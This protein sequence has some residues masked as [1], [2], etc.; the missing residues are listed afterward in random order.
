MGNKNNKPNTQH[1]SHE[2][3]VSIQFE[4]HLSNESNC[5]CVNDVC[6]CIKIHFGTPDDRF[7]AS[8]H[9]EQSEQLNNPESTIYDTAKMITNNDSP[10]LCGESSIGP[11]FPKNMYGGS[12]KQINDNKYDDVLTK[13]GLDDANYSRTTS[14]SADKYPKRISSDIIN[15]KIDNVT[16]DTDSGSDV[17]KS[18]SPN[19]YFIHS[20]SSVNVLPKYI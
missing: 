12:K 1:E 19:P 8:K 14:S 16:Y 17:K 10:R 18:S 9:S 6:R 3:V 15:K 4:K 13:L 5:H 11:I 7:D 2:N 20:E